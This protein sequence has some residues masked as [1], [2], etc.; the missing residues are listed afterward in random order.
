MRLSKV[1]PNTVFISGLQSSSSFAQAHSRDYPADLVPSTSL[2]HLQQQSSQIAP[3]CAK[4]NYSRLTAACYS[5]CSGDGGKKQT[6]VASH[7]SEHDLRSLAV[8]LSLSSSQRDT[9]TPPRRE[10]PRPPC[11]NRTPPLEMTSMSFTLNPENSL[12]PADR[13][14]T[15][16]PHSEDH[17]DSDPHTS[18]SSPSQHNSN[19]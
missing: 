12:P 7:R 1:T 9:S 10:P 6:P 16:S 19:A 13:N 14:P 5:S 4:P 18:S 8:Q 3:N 15:Q 17:W 2:F 11:S